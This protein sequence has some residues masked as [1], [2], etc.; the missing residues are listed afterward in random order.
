MAR[1][2]FPI[3]ASADVLFLNTFGYLQDDKIIPPSHFGAILLYISFC[4]F[5]SWRNLSLYIVCGGGG[6]GAN[7]VTSMEL[8]REIVKKK[9]K[10]KKNGMP[11]PL[12]R[13]VLMSLISLL[14]SRQEKNF[15]PWHFSK[16]EQARRRGKK[17]P[18]KTKKTIHTQTKTNK[19][20]RI[21]RFFLTLCPTK[22]KV[23]EKKKHAFPPQRTSPREYIGC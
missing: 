22:T 10:K 13:T 6:G 23:L 15:T 1:N 17:N 16:V 14:F 3:W 18:Q 8:A 21:R 11:K 4:I 5:F 7:M 19:Q 2:L 20:M 12:T 9:K